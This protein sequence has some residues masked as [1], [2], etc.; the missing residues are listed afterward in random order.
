[1]YKA[2]ILLQVGKN[3]W[4]SENP[5]L[6][7][8]FSLICSWICLSFH[9]A[10]KARKKYSYFLIDNCWD[11]CERFEYHCKVCVYLQSQ[12]IL[13]GILMPTSLIFLES[14]SLSEAS[15]SLLRLSLLNQIETTCKQLIFSTVK[16]WTQSCNSSSENERMG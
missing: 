3:S 9:Q 5:W 15:S 2:R 4:A 1:M 16:P 7:L 6:Y 11:I 8:R 13:E 14:L 12:Q 10:K